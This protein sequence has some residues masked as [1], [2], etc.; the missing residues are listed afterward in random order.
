MEKM[1]DSLVYHIFHQRGCVRTKGWF[2]RGLADAKGDM[3]KPYWI[4]IVE[5]SQTPLYRVPGSDFVGGFQ[6]RLPHRFGDVE[7][8]ERESQ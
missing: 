2:I 5:F 4:N 3:L 7:I 6:E 1:F 8:R